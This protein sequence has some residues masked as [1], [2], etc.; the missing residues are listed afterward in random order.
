[1][2]PPPVTT[3]VQIPRTKGVVTKFA[4][5]AVVVHEKDPGSPFL[6]LT[7][8][9]VSRSCLFLFFFLSFFLL[10]LLNQFFLGFVPENSV[11]ISTKDK[12]LSVGDIANFN[13][14][15]PAHPAE[16]LLTIR[17]NGTN[18]LVLFFLRFL[19]F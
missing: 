8:L 19:L 9:F 12:E 11:E 17:C 5:N 1:M 14:H 15:C 10:L 18:F 2:P 6:F 3:S 7:F 16:A 4:A 13:V